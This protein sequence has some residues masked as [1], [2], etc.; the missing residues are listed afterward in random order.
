MLNLKNR[1]GPW[2]LV[3]GASS[4][5]GAA[6]VRQL[7]TEGLNIVSVAR[8]QA[9]LERQAELLRQEFG[10]R[11]RGRS[12]ELDHGNEFVKP[13]IRR[14]QRPKIPLHDLAFIKCERGFEEPLLGAKFR[15]Q[16]VAID[17]DVINKRLC[18]GPMKTM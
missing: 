7:A 14:L 9:K 1:Y 5:I 8:T 2:A 10:L 4:G 13:G 15:K 11:A 17:L 6:L 18:R 16:A 12:K 3:T